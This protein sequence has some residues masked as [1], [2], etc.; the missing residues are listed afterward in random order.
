MSVDKQPEDIEVFTSFCK[1]QLV[2]TKSKIYEWSSFSGSEYIF[3]QKGWQD[4][5][6]C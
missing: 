6:W 4:F 1:M 5:Y 3:Y 2:F